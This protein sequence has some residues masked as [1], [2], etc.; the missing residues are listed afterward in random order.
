MSLDSLLAL[1][2]RAPTTTPATTGFQVGGALPWPLAKNAPRMA[3]AQ[4][5]NL[6]YT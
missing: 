5:G 6:R 4:L 2:A 3:T 1:A